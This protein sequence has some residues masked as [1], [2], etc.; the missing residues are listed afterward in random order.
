M[1]PE[2]SSLCQCQL[3]N[4]KIITFI[5]TT[6]KCASHIYTEPLFAYGAAL[7]RLSV[8]IV[9][10]LAVFME[11]MFIILFGC[12]LHFALCHRGRGAA[13][14]LENGVWGTVGDKHAWVWK[15]RGVCMLN[16]GSQER[17]SLSS[18][19]TWWLT[20][21]IPF[22]RNHHPSL[23]QVFILNKWPDANLFISMYPS[24]HP[25]VHSSISIPLSIHPSDCLSV[26]PHVCP[27]IHPPAPFH[28]RLR[29]NVLSTW[30]QCRS[31]SVFFYWEVPSR[32]HSALL[33]T[34]NVWAW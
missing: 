22:N 14:P 21:M 6:P 27:S 29:P 3:G 19:S 13:H 31:Y 18:H 1:P 25:S 23:G 16:P 10:F 5:Y 30:F 17:F 2:A 12:W 33:R 24:I 20:K 9:Y 7:R 15:G 11:T 4:T 8:H 26:H 34:P 28:S 32:G